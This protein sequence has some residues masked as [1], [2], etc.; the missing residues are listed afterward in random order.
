MVQ[1][2]LLLVIR[3]LSKQTKKVWKICD[4]IQKSS[5]LRK[6]HLLSS[7]TDISLMSPHPSIQDIVTQREIRVFIEWI[8]ADI[9]RA[10]HVLHLL[11][12]RASL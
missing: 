5:S 1:T 4:R 12:A 3:M 2:Q 11:H 8:L 10:F 6:L 7:C 9:H